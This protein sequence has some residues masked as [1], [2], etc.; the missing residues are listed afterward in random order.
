MPSQLTFPASIR[1][2]LQTLFALA[3]SSAPMNDN[4]AERFIAAWEEVSRAGYEENVARGWWTN[5]ITDER[6]DRNKAELIA[7][8]HSEL[9][10][11]YE[12]L[13]LRKKDDKLPTHF[14][15]NVERAD[16]GIRF[17]DFCGGFY[18]KLSSQAN[19]ALCAPDV[20]ATKAEDHEYNEYA[21]L[22][23][24]LSGVLE[25][26]RRKRDPSAAI[27]RFVLVLFHYP[28]AL[29]ECWIEKCIYNQKRP[30]HKL[31]ERKLADGKKF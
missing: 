12:A 9:S 3:Q 29:I 31:D 25:A 11:A 16:A 24:L 5:I 28:P 1:Y 8:T 21:E 13:M 19:Q 6:L 27:I 20:T 4:T 14:G 26:V 15:W 17:A 30:D 18:P 22:H 7:L 10:E 23:M 2:P